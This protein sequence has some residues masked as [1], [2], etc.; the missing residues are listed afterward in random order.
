MTQKYND[1]HKL[2]LINSGVS[3][4]IKLSSVREKNQTKCK[5]KSNENEKH[6]QHVT[7][8]NIKLP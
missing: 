8:K 1:N 4:W 2:Q 3:K 5:W 6:I 7:Q